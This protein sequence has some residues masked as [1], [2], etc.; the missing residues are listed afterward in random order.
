MNP[1]TK[2]GLCA[3]GIS[4]LA[5]IGNIGSGLCVGIPAE[6]RGICLG[7]SSG[8]KTVSEALQKRI[9]CPQELCTRGVPGPVPVERSPENYC[10]C[11]GP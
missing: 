9:T 7:A 5:F 6:Y 4:V 1:K 8:A 2:I 3:F 10:I 11:Y